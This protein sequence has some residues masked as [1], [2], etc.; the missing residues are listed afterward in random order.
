[1]PVRLNQLQRQGATLVFPRVVV[2][3]IGAVTPIGNDAETFWRNVVAGKTGIGPI[4]QFDASKHSVRIAAEVK[5]FDPAEVM[6]HRTAR[7]S[8][9]FSQRCS[10]GRERLHLSR[11]DIACADEF[12]PGARLCS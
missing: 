3:G 10:P 1:M 7:R 6:D 12:I 8:A 4:T 5:G 11:W 2:T 9:R